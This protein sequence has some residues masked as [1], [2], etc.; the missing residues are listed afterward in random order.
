MARSNYAM[1]AEETDR[2]PRWGKWLKV[3][4]VAFWVVLW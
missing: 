1:R 3:I 4:F 2:A